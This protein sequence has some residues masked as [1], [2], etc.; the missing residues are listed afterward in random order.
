[1]PAAQSKQARPAATLRR[2]HRRRCRCRRGFTAEE[3]KSD[4]WGSET[5]KKWIKRQ[6]NSLR[7]LLLEYR[8]NAHNGLT[9]EGNRRY[10]EEGLAEDRYPHISNLYVVKKYVND[11]PKEFWGLSWPLGRALRACNAMERMLRLCPKQGTLEEREIPKRGNEWLD[12]YASDSEDYDNDPEYDS[13]D[14]E[15]QFQ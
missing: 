11:H 15:W 3:R 5:V 9:D 14:D 12:P 4:Y 13:E 6:R 10:D 2:S 1:M 7:A 8:N